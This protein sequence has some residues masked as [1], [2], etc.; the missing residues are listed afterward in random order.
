[1][2]FVVLRPKLDP[3]CWDGELVVALKLLLHDLHGNEMPKMKIVMET[4]KISVGI[5]PTEPT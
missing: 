2:L 5:Q 4:M 1:M 3:N